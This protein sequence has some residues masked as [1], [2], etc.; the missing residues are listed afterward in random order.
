MKR[1]TTG[2]I[3]VAALI[4]ALTPLVSSSAPALAA[5]GAFSA[6]SAGGFHSM[7]IKT[8]GSLWMWGNN[9]YGQI[10]N[11]TVTDCP[12]PFKLMDSVAAVSA[13]DIHSMAVKT[14]GSLWAWGRN[15]F[16]QLGDGT[17]TERHTPVK[18]MDSVAAV[19]AGGSH[20]LAI[21]TDGSLWAWGGNSYGQLGDGTTTGR[22]GPVKIM[23]NV[24]A[25]SAGYAHSMAIKA[26]GSL[27]A[28]GSNGYGQ[29]GDGTATDRRTPVRIVGDVTDVST[30]AFFTTAVKSDGSLWVWGFNVGQLGT[31]ANGVLRDFSAAPVRIMDDVASVSAGGEHIMAIKTDGSLWACGGNTYGQLGDGTETDRYSPGKVMDG[32]A[33]VSSGG[34]HTA[35]IRADGSLWAWGS[36]YYHQIGNYE[37]TS[38][39]PPV[40]IS[41]D[42]ISVILDGRVLIFDVPPRIVNN[43]TMVPLRVIFEAL[44]ASIVWNND[45]RTVT[46]VKDDTVIS[47][48]IG[49]ATPTINGQP[50]TI[51]QPMFAVNGR[52]FVPLRFIAEAF[53]VK[54][55][56]LN[57]AVHITTPPL[58]IDGT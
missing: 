51:D 40:E 34:A 21:K 26:D 20:T 54:V 46:A 22:S 45:T 25:I 32:V 1:K 38:P 29:L 6:V 42:E 35:A 11:G 39:C 30:G 23:E 15:S 27:W 56:Y 58:F 24:A 33:A 17:I 13:G 9:R 49:D 5:G 12:V 4:L 55:D 36:N 2:A 7:A 57:G 47:L 41:F 52:T 14:D 28:W 16:G 48:T 10:G 8:D 43:R 3:L 53:G 44:G 19:S 37:T 31:D 50:V 18:V